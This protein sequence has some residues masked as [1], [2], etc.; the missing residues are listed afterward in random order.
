MGMTNY[1]CRR[2]TGT[3]DE[4]NSQYRIDSPPSPFV[5][6]GPP[7]HAL[8]RRPRH[9]CTGLTGVVSPLR[10]V[11]EWGGM[12]STPLA[13]RLFLAKKNQNPRLWRSRRWWWL[14]HECLLG[15]WW[16]C[17][18]WK[19]HG[20]RGVGQGH[21]ICWRGGAARAGVAQDGG[22]PPRVDL[23]RALSFPFEYVSHHNC[24][25]LFL[26]A[27]MYVPLA[28]MLVP[29]SVLSMCSH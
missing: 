21:G 5:Q 10:G 6:N 26:F 2:Q 20:G 11:G 18:V 9:I 19:R 13:P 25:G 28:S 15:G 17:G 8:S 7:F 29:L 22:M 27:L 24:L 14:H 16:Q 23:Q 3:T 12:D 1:N 4:G